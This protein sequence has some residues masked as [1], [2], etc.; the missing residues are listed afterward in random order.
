MSAIYSFRDFLRL[1]SPQHLTQSLFCELF[2][3]YGDTNFPSSLF[4]PLFQWEQTLKA[5][6]F[7]FLCLFFPGFFHSSTTP[8]SRLWA[9]YLRTLSLSVCPRRALNTL[10]IISPLPQHTSTIHA[11]RVL[12]THLYPCDHFWLSGWS[13]TFKSFPSVIFHIFPIPHPT[14]L[15]SVLCSPP[16]IC[17]LAVAALL[18]IISLR[19]LFSVTFFYFVAISLRHLFCLSALLCYLLSVRVVVFCF[20]FF[21]A[22]VFR[23]TLAFPILDLI[24]PEQ[25]Y[26]AYH[27]FL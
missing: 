21:F 27:L 22:P 2:L 13:R 11:S 1:F 18:V 17:A 15:P 5:T 14:L 4:D 6:P 24:S 7:R 26:W 19:H 10:N 25:C 3:L 9:Y 16:N 20:L 8:I 23:W 12:C